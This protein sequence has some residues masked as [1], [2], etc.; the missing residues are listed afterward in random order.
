M[1]FLYNAWYMIGWSDELVDGAMIARTV[2]NMPI[3]AFRGR[4]GDSLHAM[5]DRCPH[6]F[7]PLS[8]GKLSEDGL[9]CGYH[10]L[11]FDMSGRCVR[12]VFAKTAPSAA[13]VRTFPIA[14][15]PST[16]W[17]WTGDPGKADEKRIPDIGYHGDPAMRYVKGV[18]T[19]KSDYRLLID[20][21]MDL[22]HSTFIHPAFGG[23]EYM[24]RFH[25]EE[26][27]DGSI[28]SDYY[29]ADMINIFG[30]DAIPA[31]RIRNRDTIRW[32]APST[33][34]LASKAGLRDSDEN[35]IDVPSAHIL[36][37]E[38]EKTTHY[39]WSSG[40]ARASPIPDEEL[41]ATLQQ[42]FDAEDKPMVEAVQ[43]RM[44]NADLWDLHPVL[45]PTDASCVRV[46][47][48]LAA[49]IEAE[50]ADSASAAAG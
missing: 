40:V 5:E 22:C 16:I 37:P 32:I 18:T 38:S 36:T 34:I 31:D 17:V 26:L 6:R 45:L 8:R 20:N 23:L 10:G 15:R 11:T 21:L 12:N 3:V 13:R 33:H 49:L 35:L 48:K 14:E 24:P 43:Q 25:S 30:A 1:S 46:R 41:F 29:I 2:L 7:A 44:G 4:D 47:R 50:H 39:F 28:V 42:A 19:V 9:Q 27:P